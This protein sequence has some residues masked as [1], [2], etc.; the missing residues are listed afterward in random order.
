[1]ATGAHSYRVSP[2]ERDGGKGTGLVT[3]PPT[4]RNR[5]RKREQ[6]AAGGAPTQG[7]SPLQ[8]STDNGDPAKQHSARDAP[9][10]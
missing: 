1:M 2:L 9:S 10:G 5:C 4:S 7:A 3:T 6:Q 8:G